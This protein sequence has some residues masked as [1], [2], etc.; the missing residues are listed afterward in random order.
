[1]RYHGL[2]KYAATDFDRPQIGCLQ[3]VLQRQLC[4]VSP[5]ETT[6]LPTQEV[7]SCKIGCLGRSQEFG[8]TLNERRIF[9]GKHEAKDCVDLLSFPRQR[10]DLNAACWNSSADHPGPSTTRF[11]KA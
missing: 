3:R 9:A 7:E 8:N 5:Q 10:K 2:L 6:L 4:R 11:G 1:M